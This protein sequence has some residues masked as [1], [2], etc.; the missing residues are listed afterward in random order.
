MPIPGNLTVVGP[1]GDIQGSCEIEGREGTILVQ[2]FD[3]VVELPNDER[4]MVVGRRVHRPLTITK[5]IDRSTPLM[6]QALCN[7]DILPEVTLDWYRV[8]ETGTQEL[9]FQ[10]RMRNALVSKIRPWV[11]NVLD[12]NFSG[13]RHMEDI[14]FSYE[15][16]SWSWVLDGIEYEDRWADQN[17]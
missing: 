10:I 3:H 14:S 16:I 7:H 8:D 13:F 11:P 15:S 17:S 2:A 12:E 5:E 1:S 6:Y 4:G 9:Y